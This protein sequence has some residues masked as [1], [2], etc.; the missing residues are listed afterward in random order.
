[1]AKTILSRLRCSN[2]LIEEVETLIFH[3]MFEIHPHSS[4]R[5]T[6][7]FMARVGVD[8]AFQLV[9]LRQGDMGG[10]NKDP[11]LIIDYGQAMEARFKEVLEQN[12]ALTIN[13]LAINGQDLMEK[14]TLKPSPLIGELLQYLLEQ[15]LIDPKLNQKAFLLDLAQNHLKSKLENDL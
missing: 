1:M 11:R 7:R 14:F 8:T 15:V 13:D 4:D 3:H 5:A 10:M 2:K 9:K 6:R 12:A